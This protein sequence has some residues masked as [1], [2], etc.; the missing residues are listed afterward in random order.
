MTRLRVQGG[1]RVSQEKLLGMDADGV[2]VGFVGG[3]WFLSESGEGGELRLFGEGGWTR[4]R[5]ETHEACANYAWETN[6]SME[7]GGGAGGCVVGVEPVRCGLE[8][9]RGSG[10]AKLQPSGSSGS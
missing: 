7:R 4:I 6:E 10:G 3:S 9:G 5:L 8:R 2:H 1:R